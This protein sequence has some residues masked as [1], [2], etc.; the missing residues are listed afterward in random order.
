MIFLGFISYGFIVYGGKL[1]VSDEDLILNAKTTIETTDGQVI[2]ELYDENRKPVE[3]DAIPK[4][5]Q[6]AF[7]AVEDQR[8][9]QHAG[10]DF[11][12][13]LRAVY[14]DII[15]LDKVEG[16]VRLLSN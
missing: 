7:I 4:H 13:V 8:F 9:Y 16:Q 2:W 15:A 14:R 10:V 12:A 3:I 5:V 6:H 1:V 11:K